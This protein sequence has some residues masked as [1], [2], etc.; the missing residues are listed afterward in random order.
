MP[1]RTPPR[2][3]APAWLVGAVGSPPPAT[4]HRRGPRARPGPVDPALDGER[5]RVQRQRPPEHHW[6]FRP[7]QCRCVATLLI[8][9]Y[10]L[11]R[12]NPMTP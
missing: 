12:P 8:A 10:L 1:I 11:G 7:V 3:L 4:V 6:T 9:R 2:E 5:D